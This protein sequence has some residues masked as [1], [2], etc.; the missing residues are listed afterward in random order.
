MQLFRKT[1]LTSLIIILSLYV[2]GSGDK[3]DTLRYEVLLNSKILSDLDLNPSFIRNFDITANQLILI[4]SK[5]QFYLVGWGGLLPFGKP[6]TGDI[7]S[8]AFTQDSI[9]LTVRN[10][11]LCY[12]DA[13]GKLS[14]LY[15]LPGQGMGISKGDQVMYI[16]DR[17]GVK[18]NYAIYVVAQGGRYTKLLDM[19]TP[20]NEVIEG[21]NSILFASGSVLFDFDFK[22][23]ELKTVTVLPAEKE[24]K[25]IAVDKPAGRIYFSTGKEIYALK[26]TGAVLISDD[27]SGFLRIYG[28]GL[29]VFSP[30][31]KILL[32]IIGLEEQI[33][34]N[35][36]LKTATEIKKTVDVLT[37]S[38]V[39]D[40]VN[41]KLSDALII[42]LITH[43]KVDFNLTTDAVIELSN[44]GVSP[45]VIMEMRQAMKRQA[46]GQQK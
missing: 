20:I 24:I 37:N 31:E 3:N 39:I 8:F 12:F 42:A 28:N 17:T 10:D 35:T 9:L 19:P 11:E 2:Y 16:Y 23:R 18:D 27:L 46:S 32:R 44:N 38:T 6:V 30:E 33:A 4:S 7:S 25:S 34:N 41:K 13:E 14:L 5:N 43:A 29:M 45:E 1:V 15:R 36:D 21:N 40:L 22:S 26:D